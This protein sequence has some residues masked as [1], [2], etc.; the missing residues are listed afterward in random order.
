M[1]TLQA[2]FLQLRKI[3]LCCALLCFTACNNRAHKT[4]TVQNPQPPTPPR[5]YEKT[6][7]PEAVQLKNLSRDCYEENTKTYKIPCPDL[8]DPVC[9]CDNKNYSNSCEAER[10]GIKK[11]EK[12]NCK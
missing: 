10:A 3:G 4:P 9:G 8:F 6:K 1:K 5:T 11:W 2:N 7:A 12:G